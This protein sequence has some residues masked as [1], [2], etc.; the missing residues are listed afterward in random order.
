MNHNSYKRNIF[1]RCIYAT[2]RCPVVMKDTD[3]ITLN[4]NML[5]S[6]ALNFGRRHESEPSVMHRYKSDPCEIA[7]WSPWA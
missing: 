1:C 3:L 4:S 5:T 7:K 6:L 2:E